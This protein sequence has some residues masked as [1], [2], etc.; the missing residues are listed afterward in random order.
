M[1]WIWFALEA[2]LAVI[3]ASA[4][5]LKIFFKQ[6]LK[7]GSFASSFSFRKTHSTEPISNSAGS[8]T[9]GRFSKTRTQKMGLN[10]ITI[11]TE[12][13]TFELSAIETREKPFTI[14]SSEERLSDAYDNTFEHTDMNRM[15]DE[16]AGRK[17]NHGTFFVE[18]DSE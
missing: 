3:C 5:A 16:E 8:T 10:D 2:H 12:D 17:R 6:T 15:T 9:M 7:V 1:A 4:P 18:T 13:E 11:D 14:F